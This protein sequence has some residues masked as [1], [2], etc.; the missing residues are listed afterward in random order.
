VSDRKYRKRVGVVWPEARPAHWVSRHRRFWVVEKCLRV[1]WSEA[2]VGV[3]S[4]RDSSIDAKGL[5]PVF[6]LVDE[7]DGVR[8]FSRNS[9]TTT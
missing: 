5:F 8:H 6:P 7:T 2:Q 4:R 3:Y 9:V 1:D